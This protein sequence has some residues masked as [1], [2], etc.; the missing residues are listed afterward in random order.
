[1]MIMMPVDMRAI[2]RLVYVSARFLRAERI[3]WFFYFLRSG[4]VR[5]I[6]MGFTCRSWL[7]A[8]VCGSR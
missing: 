1:M 4:N 6:S 8:G 5:E 3:L 2:I 7:E